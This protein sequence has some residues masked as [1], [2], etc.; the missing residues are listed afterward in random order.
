MNNNT[1]AEE[2][3]VFNEFIHDN[4]D[5]RQAFKKHLELIVDIG[6]FDKDFDSSVEERM[7]ED[8]EDFE[9]AISLNER[10]YIDISI[11]ELKKMINKKRKT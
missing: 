6:E 3:S 8:L 10:P 2:L 7:L 4:E 5:V 9:H 11:D 1:M